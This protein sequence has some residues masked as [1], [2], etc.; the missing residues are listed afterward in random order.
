MKSII[1]AEVN[2][3]FEIHSQNIELISI[4]NPDLDEIEVLSKEIINSTKE[5]ELRWV[6]DINDLGYIENS[7][8]ASLSSDQKNMLIDQ[9]SKSSKILGTI[10]KC[11]KFTVRL[12]K[13]RSPMC[14]L[15]HVDQI[16]CRLLI[17]LYG[18]GTEWIENDM[19][20]WEILLDRHNMN[21]PLKEHGKIRQNEHWK[22]VLF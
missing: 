4:K 1:S 15:F 13:L 16:P 11:S 3:F 19:V 12:A 17:S 7:L 20:D 10:L 22:L 18:H 6:Q 8:P 9:I 5:L 14:P 21:V 2:D